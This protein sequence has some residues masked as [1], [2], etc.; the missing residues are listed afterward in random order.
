MMYFNVS[1]KHLFD[2]NNQ[3]SLRL[4]VSPPLR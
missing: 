2:N 4:P 1:I 3:F